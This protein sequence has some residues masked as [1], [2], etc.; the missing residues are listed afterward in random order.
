MLY[1]D[2]I[3]LHVLDRE[4]QESLD[5]PLPESEIMD[6]IRIGLLAS[7]FVFASYSH[8]CESSQLYPRANAELCFLQEQGAVLFLLADENIDSFFAKREKRYFKDKGRYPFYF[9]RSQ[10][11]ALLPRAECIQRTTSS[12]EYIRQGLCYL[13]KEDL[14]VSRLPAAGDPY[15]LEVIDQYLPSPNS[16]QALTAHTFQKGFQNRKIF[17]RFEDSA[18]AQRKLQA[19]LTSLHGK[20]IIA[21]TH[22]TIFT[23]I[24]GC[25]QYDGLGT[26]NYY[27]FPLYQAFLRP[28]LGNKAILKNI[29]LYHKQLEE[30]VLFRE[31]HFFSHFCGM[32][33]TLVQQTIEHKNS[34]YDFM[35][36]YDIWLKQLCSQVEEAVYYA[37][38]G[39]VFDSVTPEAAQA[40][41]KQLKLALQRTIFKG[42]ANVDNFEPTQNQKVV[43]ILTVN[44][45]EHKAFLDELTRKKTPYSAV[46]GK[47]NVY[48]RAEWKNHTLII[49]KC[50][51]GSVGPASSTLAVQ[52][53]ISEFKPAA[54]IACGVAFGCKPE[55]EHLGDIMVSKQLWQYDP[56]KV[57][58]TSIIR[59]GDKATA[60]ASLLQ[61]FSSAVVLWEKAN[62]DVSVHIGLLASGEVLANSDDFLAELKLSE[63]EIIGGEMEGAGVLS[64]AE[65]E[66][67]DWI[68]VK[69]IC[70]W[71]AKKTDDYQPQSAQNAA[72]YVLYVLDLFPLL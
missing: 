37:T 36:P 58:E 48:F 66:K 44:A 69:A 68:I 1:Q 54:V 34:S 5:R 11:K 56:Q 35:L 72:Q 64:A 62:P 67:C 19:T 38:G 43:L 39:K 47:N 30:I 2:G 21:E 3:F 70:D 15:V 49:L 25:Q 14:R 40:Y 55:K 45:E 17:K 26:G 31:N 6:L 46:V 12:T 63:P 22:S 57:T 7:K 10:I 20:S 28:L 9:D 42:G 51:P 24:P 8:V 4:L 71:G 13:L 41:L 65:R 50:M 18:P 59:R 61:R 60:S 53:A 27:S 33:Y 52:E 23:N 16:K 29:A 32:I